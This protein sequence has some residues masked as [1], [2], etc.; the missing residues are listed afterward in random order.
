MA[1]LKLWFCCW[2]LL[3]IR[4]IYLISFFLFRRPRRKKC[5][6]ACCVLIFLGIGVCM[7]V[8]KIDGHVRTIECKLDRNVITVNISLWVNKHTRRIKSLY[9]VRVYLHKYLHVYMCTCVCVSACVFVYVIV[10][11]QCI[12]FFLFARFLCFQRERIVFIA[13]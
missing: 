4:V 1:C 11:L 8:C 13:K 2:L 9:T 12:I 3:V 10:T 5:P 6:L 7:H